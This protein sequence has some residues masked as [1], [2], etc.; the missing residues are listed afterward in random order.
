M[1]VFLHKYANNNTVNTRSRCT[2]G[3]YNYIY[4]YI[5]LLY[6]IWNF[7]VQV[8]QL[9]NYNYIYI[10]LSIQNSQP[11]VPKLKTPLKTPRCMRQLTTTLQLLLTR[12]SPPTAIRESEIYQSQ[13]GL[14]QRNI[15]AIIPFTNKHIFHTRTILIDQDSI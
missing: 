14:K 6:H 15:E 5:I 7:T 13:A 8:E 4:N 9:K 12:T 1:Y 3:I 11:C 10:H 2:R